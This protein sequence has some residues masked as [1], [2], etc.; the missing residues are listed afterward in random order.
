MSSVRQSEDYNTIQP[1]QNPSV[2]KKG[3]FQNAFVSPR[4]S[5]RSP[6]HMNDKDYVAAIRSSRDQSISKI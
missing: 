3:V 6:L 1:G 4:E 2:K 5:Q